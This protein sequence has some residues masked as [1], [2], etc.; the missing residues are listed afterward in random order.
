MCR[1]KTKKKKYRMPHHENLIAALTKCKLPEVLQR[2][3][4]QFQYYASS[5]S[6]KYILHHLL[7]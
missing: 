3:N 1:P 5:L 7:Y 2:G 4:K 6:Q